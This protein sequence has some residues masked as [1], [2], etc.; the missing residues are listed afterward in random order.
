[1]R[2]YCP[3]CNIGYE[4]KDSLI[5]EEGRKLKCSNCGEIFRFDRNGNSES[6][7]PN[8]KTP[9]QDKQEEASS[10]IEND[11]PSSEILAE[12]TFATEELAETS[13]SLPE[14]TVPNPQMPEDEI[15]IKDIFERLNEQ[16]EHLFQEEQ[17]LPFKQRFLLEIKTMLGLYRKFNFKFIG[18]IAVF[19]LILTAYNYRYDIVRT[20]PFTNIFYKIFGIKA[21][22][23]GEG[24]EFQNINWNYTDNEDNRILEVKGFINN[25]TDRT[26]EIPT[27][28]VELL[29]K[30]SLLLQSINQK[31]SIKS[32]KTDERVAIGIV[33]KNPSPTAKYVYMTFIEF[34]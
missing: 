30:D 22:V 33:I 16:S 27:I 6:I 14:E 32:L 8:K 7:F 20:V 17:K 18:L 9:H 10:S 31:P 34:D 12:K 19:F 15:N 5:P 21:Q 1:M 11:T 23:P 28:H 4:V 13:S 3:Q 2:I 26:I 24:L 29:D 25:P